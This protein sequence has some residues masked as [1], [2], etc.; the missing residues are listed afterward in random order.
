MKG[1][2]IN[3]GYSKYI[4]KRITWSFLFGATLHY[5]VKPLFYT[6]PNGENVDG[7]IRSTT[8]GLQLANHLGY[9]LIKTKSH[10]FEIRAGGLLRY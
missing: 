9:N 8:G 10:Q 7:S 6:A 5:N 2:M 4:R 1:V 3:T